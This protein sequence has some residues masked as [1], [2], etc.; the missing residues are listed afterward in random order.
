M[1]GTEKM[2]NASDRS[3]DRPYGAISLWLLVAA[4][5]PFVVI[6]YV[7]QWRLVHYQFFPFALLAFGWLYH[8]RREEG[9]FVWGRISW[10]L[11][12]ADILL[13][14]AGTF[15]N[16]PFLV[17]LGA[18]LLA[19]AVCRSSRDEGFYRPLS[20]LCLLPLLSIRLPLN[21]DRELIQ[22]L[23]SVTTRISS[24]FL[25]EFGYL[26]VREENV[27]VFP[28]K[29]FLVEEACSGVQSLF[30]LLFVAALISC[31]SRRKLFHTAFV[32]CSAVL[33]AGFMNTVRVTVIAM[34]WHSYGMDLSTGWQHDAI[35]YI[36]LLTA[37]GFV[38]SADAL[39][40]FFTK[41]VPDISKTSVTSTHRNPLITAW[42]WFFA[43]GMKARSATASAK[44]ISN[45]KYGRLLAQASGGLCLCAFTVQA[46][47]L[48]QDVPAIISQ[49]LRT[50]VDV[51]SE[52]SLPETAEGFTRQ[53]YEEV[54]RGANALEGEFSNSWTYA[55]ERL[56][57]Y[58]SCDHP[59]MEWH[60]LTLCYEKT[61]WTVSDIQY[62]DSA[63]WPHLIARLHQQDSGKYAILLFSHFDQL[64]NPVEPPDFDNPISLIGR[65]LTD[66]GFST[67]MIP[68]VFQ[69]QVFSV[70]SLQPPD[71]D[72]QEL[73]QLHISLRNVMRSEVTSKLNGSE[74]L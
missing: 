6:H 44:A 73:T 55:H 62:Q 60:P 64:G 12:A 17:V 35:G 40:N 57:A 61:G 11:V 15:L 13:L 7:N 72:I 39:L 25:H 23:Q 48:R 41:S 63:D 20:Y 5:V 45:L 32:L 43:R 37:S 24:R 54:E 4:H 47:A 65:R 22:S 18:L 42:N 56:Q 31:I 27:L 28:E 49:S 68:V 33:F 74:K 46:L 1:T 66:H 69:S 67:S 2:T 51:L 9:V 19:Y 10:C 14:C 59:F 50:Q 8:N 16:S 52:D 34:A 3:S 21:F 30:T 36:A 58:V 71:S 26:H 70:F 29:R 38:F 53:T